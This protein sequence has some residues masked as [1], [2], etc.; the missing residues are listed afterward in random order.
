[1]SSN[2]GFEML[3]KWQTTSCSVELISKDPISAGR[4]N[5]ER[6][7]IES[8][9]PSSLSLSSLRSGEVRDRSLVG[10]TF[11]GGEY[12]LSIRFSDGSGFDL[13]P[14]LPGADDECGSSM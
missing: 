2:D 9:D 14:T 1:M 12:A 8:V 7:R 11:D 13:A 5:S 10:A 4:I 3:K 6:V